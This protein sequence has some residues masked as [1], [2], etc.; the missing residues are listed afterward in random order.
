MYQLYIV[1]RLYL[2]LDVYRGKV[3]IVHHGCHPQG[4]QVCLAVSVWSTILVGRTPLKT[5]QT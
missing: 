5:P 4:E 2:W 1:F 3:V